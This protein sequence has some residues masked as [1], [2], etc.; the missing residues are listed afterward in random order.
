M[1]MSATGLSDATIADLS[2]S[3][4]TAVLILGGPDAVS[5][6]AAATLRR[7]T[8]GLVDASGRCR[9]IRHCSDGRAVALQQ[10]CK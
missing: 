9:S 3:E 8:S 1:A 4:P 2:A 5:E 6:A 7:H 10:H